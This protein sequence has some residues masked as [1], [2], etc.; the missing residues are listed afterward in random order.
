MDKSVN[1]KIIGLSICSKLIYIHFNI[2]HGRDRRNDRCIDW[3]CYQGNGV[4]DQERA[5][6]IHK[7]KEASW[8]PQ[9]TSQ[10]QQREA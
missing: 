7:H 2:A 6:R 9:Q 3:K 4:I 8:W 1:Q 5:K 10:G